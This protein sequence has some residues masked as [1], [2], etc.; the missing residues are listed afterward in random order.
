M[1]VLGII[2]SQMSGHLW[3]P[4]GAYDSIATA[5]GTGSSG[6][7]TLSSIPSTY[8]HLQIRISAQTTGTA[9]GKLSFN[10]DTTNANYKSHDLIG[11]GTT[12]SSTS[13]AQSYGGILI[14]A[15]GG[16]GNTSGSASS[17]TLIDI[18]DYA[19][20]NKYKTTRGLS[21]LDNNG[22]DH[23]V[24]FQSGVWLSTAAISSITL[25]LSANS[26]A[27]LSQFALYGIK[28]V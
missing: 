22:A 28:G 13:Y 1:P 23:T 3:A 12:A 20:T 10:S 26:F 11:D 2:A 15:Y 8:T 16:W 6:T 9:Y 27:S 7:I 4:S 25:T 21:G 14:N 18:L 24:V 19:N 5:N 17:A